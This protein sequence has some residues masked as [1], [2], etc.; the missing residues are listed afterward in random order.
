MLLP[1]K[2]F[3]KIYFVTKETQN[4]APLLARGNSLVRQRLRPSFQAL[5]PLAPNMEFRSDNAALG[6]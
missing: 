3:F 2:G 5:T 1:F 4:D 6:T